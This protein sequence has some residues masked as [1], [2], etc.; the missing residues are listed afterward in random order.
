M[1][2]LVFINTVIKK[3]RQSYKQRYQK[4]TLTCILLSCV[5]FFFSFL[6]VINGTLQGYPKQNF[7]FFQ[8]QPKYD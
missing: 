3:N 8:N 5:D 4:Q 1:D 7:F 2:Y 6:A